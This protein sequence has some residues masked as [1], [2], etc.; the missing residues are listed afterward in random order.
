[1]VVKR[2]QTDPDIAFAAAYDP[3]MKD[4]RKQ[5]ANT[6]SGSGWRHLTQHNTF[7]LSFL[8]YLF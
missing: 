7:R 3:A 8:T 4:V 6:G 1:M 5:Q 2:W